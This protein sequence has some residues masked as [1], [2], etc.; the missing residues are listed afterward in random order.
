MKFLESGG[1]LCLFVV[2]W[3]F[4]MLFAGYC[5]KA[6]AQEITLMPCPANGQWVFK[7]PFAGLESLCEGVEHHEDG[8]LIPRLCPFRAKIKDAEFHPWASVP[9]TLFLKFQETEEGKGVT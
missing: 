3:V 4:L 1:G 8:I 2:C 7:G 5:G 9:C 6:D